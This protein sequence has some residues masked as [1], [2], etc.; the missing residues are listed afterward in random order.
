MWEFLKSNPFVVGALSGSL[1][2]YLI[3]LVVSYLRRE[4]RWLGYSVSSRNIVYG[5]HSKLTMKYDG[6]D[7]VRLDSHTVVIRN[8][9]NRPLVKLPIRI[10]CINGGG[11]VEHE[12]HAPD[13]ASCVAASDGS[14]KLVVTTDLL[15]PGEVVTIGL[16]VA[17]AKEGE[18]KVIAR[19]EFLEVKKIG[20]RADTAE[21]LEALMP[22]LP[23]I[24]SLM[25]DLYRLSRPRRR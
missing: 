24:G 21:L 15:N 16:T 3:G 1:A 18:I 8:I 5:G 2:A 9:G 6:K 4:K 7:I 11:I 25:F 23:F 10:E 13:G 12:L 22:H 19:G 17:D 14:G 20:E